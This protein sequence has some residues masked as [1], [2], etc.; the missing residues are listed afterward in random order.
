MLTLEE[1]RATRAKVNDLSS[2]FGIPNDDS[3]QRPGYT[4]AE[5]CYLIICG[6]GRQP[7]Y[8]L[9]IGPKEWTSPDLAAQ[10][11]RLYRN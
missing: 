9:G 5:D 2:Y 10:E 4:Y 3:A 8:Y 1:F 7:R 11:E 6:H